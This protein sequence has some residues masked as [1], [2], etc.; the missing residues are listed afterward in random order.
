MFV[1]FRVSSAR[2]QLEAQKWL[3]QFA[4]NTDRV[5]FVIL[6]T[7]SGDLADDLATVVDALG[8]PS[9]VDTKI[10]HIYTP[11]K[12]NSSGAS[13]RDGSQKVFRLTKPPRTLK[14][15]Q[16]LVQLRNPPPQVTVPVPEKVVEDKPVE[17][18][19]GKRD[20]PGTKIL[21]AEGESPG[22]FNQE[23]DSPL[24]ATCTD[25]PIARKLLKAQL[26]RVNLQVETTTNGEEAV[27]AWE[28]HG[29]GY[30]RAAMFD[31]RRPDESSGS[32]C[33]KLTWPLRYACMRRGRSC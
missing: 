5:D 29:P 3:G 2:T 30:F 7:Q 27:A 33:L 17:D 10:V 28:K 22:F 32:Y 23:V 8:F 6:D 4:G 25:N 20:F 9:L 18:A 15:L 31:H 14:M 1:G 21:I 13:G 26:Q 19:D 24:T 11:T 16:T 12:G